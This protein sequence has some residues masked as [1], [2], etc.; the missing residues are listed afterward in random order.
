MQILNDIAE[1]VNMSEGDYKNTRFLLSAAQTA[2]LPEDRGSEVVLMGYSN[3][4]KSSTLNAITQSKQLARVSKTPGRT[5][6]LNVFVIDDERRFIDVPG[7]GYAKAPSKLKQSWHDLIDRYLT[8]RHSIRGVVLIMDIRHPL[9]PF[10]TQMLTWG[11]QCRL[12][13]HV[14]LN[15]V[16][17]LTQ[18][19]AQKTLKQV[20]AYIDEHGYDVSLQLFSTMKRS[21][22]KGLITVLDHWFELN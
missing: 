8:E 18:R 10:E 16:D 17:K 9:K 13:M 11:A 3:V 12:D 20:Q 22:L 14:V 6:C 1:Q 2:Q 19:E 4:G 5:Q 7:F 21:G 15:K